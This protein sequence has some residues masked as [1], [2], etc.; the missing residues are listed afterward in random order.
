MKF[1]LPPGLGN[2]DSHHGRAG[3]DVRAY[4]TIP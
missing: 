4:L 1:A 3:C 2:G